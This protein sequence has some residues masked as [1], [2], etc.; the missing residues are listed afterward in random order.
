M[1]PTRRSIAPARG[2]FGTLGGWIQRTRE[3]IER[4]GGT[5][6]RIITG[7]LLC[8]CVIHLLPFA[9]VLGAG[10]LSQAYGVDVTDPTVLVLLRHRAVLFGVV[11]VGFLAAAFKRE[12]Q[13]TAIAVALV[14][15]ITFV[16]LAWLAPAVTPQLDRVA[17]VDAAA[18]VLL[19]V[20]AVLRFWSRDL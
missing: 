17:I 7:I 19:I 16:L 18:I 20:A 4:D 13:P 2:S 6:K 1:E 9:G 8:V 15:T 5:V 11:G 3:P 10:A 12:W 14:T